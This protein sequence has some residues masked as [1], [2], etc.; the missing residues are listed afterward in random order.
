[1]A[2]RARL[3]FY[4]VNPAQSASFAP[5]SNNG[6]PKI[7]VLPTLMTAGNLLCGYVAALQIYDGRAQSSMLHYHYAILAILLACVF[8][9]LDGRVARMGGQESPFGRELDSLADIISFGFAP[10]LLVYDVVLKEVDYRIGWPISALYLVCGALRLARFNCIAASETKPR[11]TNFKGCPIPAAAGVIASLTLLLI[12]L[13]GENRE[14]GPMKYVLV[15]LMLLLSL[16]MVSSLEYPSF[17]SV[18]WRM[19]RPLHV[20]LGAIIVIVLT[21]MNWQW[22]PA[23]LFVSYLLYGLVRPWVSRRWRHEIEVEDETG[24]AVLA[25]E[26]QPLKETPEGLDGGRVAGP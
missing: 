19:R 23:V 8:D 5:V 20:V 14:I 4:A 24:E 18:N 3:G 10:T 13:E 12:W 25:D 11:N 17:K 22:M 2:L 26:T 1:M 21:V 15:G 9:A 16:L 7:Y 6:E